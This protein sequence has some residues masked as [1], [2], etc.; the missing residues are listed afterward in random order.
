[1]SSVQKRLSAKVL[2]IGGSRVWLNP[3]KM[4]D[5]EKAITKIDIRKL[6]KKGDIKSLP[7]K[8]RIKVPMK[9]RKRGHGSKKGRKHSI[10][11]SK[12]KWINT[13]MPQRRLLSE[14][15]TDGLIDGK[16]YRKMYKLVKGGMFRSR[17][18]LKLYMQQSRILKG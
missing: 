11:P 16:T 9:N 18:H 8:V 15:K 2:K 12:T 17:S 10:V 6:V 5:I 14:L 3:D 1:M 7:E 13:V 4:K